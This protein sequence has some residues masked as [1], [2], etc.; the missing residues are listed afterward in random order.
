MPQKAFPIYAECGGLMY[1]VKNIVDFQGRVFPM[2]GVFDCSAAMANK[3][4]ALGYIEIEVRK[5]IS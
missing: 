4:Q 2:S 3:R 1:L 5:T